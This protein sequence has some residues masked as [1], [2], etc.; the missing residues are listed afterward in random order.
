MLALLGKHKVKYLIV[1]GLA[2]TYHAVPRYTK[3]MDLWIDPAKKNVE[4]ANQALREF[5]SPLLMDPDLTEEILQLGV[6]PDRIDLIR[7]IT[8]VRFE[9]AWKNRIKGIYGNAKA[10]WIDIDSLIRV[11]SRIDHPRHQ[12]DTRILREVKR[13]RRKKNRKK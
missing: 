7:S 13:L 6:A 12:E 2:F 5:G 11:K 3:D 9:T 4:Q 10:Y 1:G 8:G